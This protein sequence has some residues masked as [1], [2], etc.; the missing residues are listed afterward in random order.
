[1]AILGLET[2]AEHAA[3]GVAISVTTIPASALL[4]VAAGLGR[5]SQATS[6][7]AV[8]AINVAMILAGS[9]LTLIAAARGAPTEPSRLRSY[10]YLVLTDAALILPPAE[11]NENSTSLLCPAPLT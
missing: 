6:A 10:G 2:K 5:L 8:L 11:L 9:T 1:M 4:G 7:L 3:V